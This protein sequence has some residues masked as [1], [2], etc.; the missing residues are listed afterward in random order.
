M[1]LKE[2]IVGCTISV[3]GFAHPFSDLLLSSASSTLK[4]AFFLLAKFKSKNTRFWSF[5][6]AGSEENNNNSN[7]QIRTFSFHC[8]AKNRIG[9]L[10]ILI[11]FL[12]YS[13]TWLNL[14]RDDGH[15]FYLFLPMVASLTTNK[16][17]EKKHCSEDECKSLL[18]HHSWGVSCK[19]RVKLLS[20]TS[21]ANLLCRTDMT[22]S[23]V[24]LHRWGKQNLGPPVQ[25]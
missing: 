3:P 17:P 5:S 13:H 22:F 18:L 23:A 16:T 6:V 2:K 24:Q 15:F 20:M 19:Q 21:W 14:L 11:V 25:Y 9:R 10:R 7:L 8:V 1:S 4:V 12:A